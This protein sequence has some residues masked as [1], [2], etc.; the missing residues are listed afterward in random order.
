[1]MHS[2]CV[3]RL[4]NVHAVV[5]NIG[6]HTEHGV[7][8]SR[9]TRATDGKPEASVLPHNEG[10]RHRRQWAL[11]WSYSIPFSVDNAVQVCRL[12]FCPHVV[13]FI[14]QEPCTTAA[15]RTSYSAC[16][17]LHPPSHRQQRR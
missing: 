7:D 17:Y 13:H 15:S 12:G 4:L 11:P 10:R 5:D 16:R 2:R 8:D 9:T 1:M 3:N 6:D 14:V